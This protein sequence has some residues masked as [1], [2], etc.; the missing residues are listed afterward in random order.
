M[1][2]LSF[3]DKRLHEKANASSRGKH[4]GYSS[5]NCPERSPKCNRCSAR[6]APFV[7]LKGHTDKVTNATFFADGKKIGTTSWDGTARIWD[8]ESGEELTKV[9]GLSGWHTQFFQDGKKIYSR[10]VVLDAQDKRKSGIGRVWDAES[11][12]KLYAFSERN[13]Y[14]GNVFPDGKK[15]STRDLTQNIVINHI[16]DAETGKELYTLTGLTTTGPFSPDGKKMFSKVDAG[17]RI[18]DTE[19]GKE[20]FTLPGWVNLDA[21]SP[22]GKKIVTAQ[23][24][25][26]RFFGFV[27]SVKNNVH[28]WDADSGKEL[29]V[30]SGEFVTTSPVFSPDGK[31]LI[32]QDATGTASTGVVVPNANALRIWDTD[33]GEELQK[34]E[35]HPCPISFAYFSSDGK[36]IVVNCSVYLN[37]TYHGQINQFW[38]AESGKVLTSLKGPFFFSPDGKKILSLENNS[39]VRILEAESEKALYALPGKFLRLSEDG[40][41]V[42][43]TNDDHTVR[44]WVLE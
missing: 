42:V 30:L 26:N 17:T 7:E 14:L 11:G 44:I 16:L 13:Q 3:V 33:S 43:T 28:M 41:K 1:L 38:D 31:K 32:T 20:L 8:T 18:W 6:T 4:S 5:G 2:T 40:E 9:T 37:Q 10:D 29:H 21:F 36:K 25:V 27:T 12:K 22:E 23:E 35:G 34:L 24:K 15:S 39:T 19:S